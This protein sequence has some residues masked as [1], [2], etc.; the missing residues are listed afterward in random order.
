MFILYSFKVVPLIQVVLN[1]RMIAQSQISNVVD[2][3]IRGFHHG[4]LWTVSLNSGIPARIS[5]GG[6]QETKQK[7]Q[8]IGPDFRFETFQDQWLTHAVLPW[9]YLFMAKRVLDVKDCL[10]KRIQKTIL[11]CLTMQQNHSSRSTVITSLCKVW[12]SHGGN[13]EHLLCPGAQRRQDRRWT[14]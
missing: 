1:G 3:S 10:E 6:S 4:T 11:Q 13:Y 14:R 7:C 2:S 5:S 12:C 9:I 8:P